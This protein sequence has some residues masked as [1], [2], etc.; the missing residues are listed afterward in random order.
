MSE[1]VR[2]CRLCPK[3]VISTG[4]TFEDD[5]L[6]V[7]LPQRNYGN[8]VKYCIVVAQDIPEETTIN[9]P[10]V[11]TIGDDATITYPFVNR[12]C[13]AIRASQ[14]RVNTVYS[15]RVFTGIEEGV[16]KY[17]GKCCLPSNATTT[18]ASLP[19]PVTEAQQSD[20]GNDDTGNNTNTR[21]KGGS[22]S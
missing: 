20:A 6:V 22:N 11:F 7:N 1:C 16:F 17:I 21:V 10:V 9:A 4:V 14:M 3:F 5:T 8:C 18:I 15:S 13:T 12:D 19:I 2:D